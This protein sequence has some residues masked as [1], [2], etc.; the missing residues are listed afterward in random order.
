MKTTT[1]T[2]DTIETHLA[3]LAALPSDETA[4]LCRGLHESARRAILEVAIS[5]FSEDG[6]HNFPVSFINK[7]QA[8]IDGAVDAEA[9]AKWEGLAHVTR[10]NLETLPDLCSW[11]V[12]L[13]RRALT[14]QAICAVWPADSTQ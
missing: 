4:R 13:R 11:L 5:V 9:R 8:R 14:Y 7:I 6:S 10:Q 2:R 3:H 12:S 1:L